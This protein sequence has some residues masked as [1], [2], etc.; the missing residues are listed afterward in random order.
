MR[1]AP[2]L[3]GLAAVWLCLCTALAG[4]GRE[5]GPDKPFLEATVKVN[6][7]ELKDFSLECWVEPGEGTGERR[8]L[9]FLVNGQTK[10]KLELDAQDKLVAEGPQG[11]YGGGKVERGRWTHVAMVS[12]G[13][14]R[15][16]RV[17][18]DGKTVARKESANGNGWNANEFVFRIGGATK[19]DKRFPGRIGRVAWHGRALAEDEIA[20]IAADR[21]AVPANPPVLSWTLGPGDGL[22]STGTA[23]AATLVE[24]TTASAA[25]PAPA[26]PGKGLRVALAGDGWV[27]RGEAGQALQSLLG[28]GHTVQSFG[29]PGLTA[30]KSGATPWL[31]SEPARK[32]AEF[33]PALVVVA[34]GASDTAGDHRARLDAWGADM[35]EI[36]LSLQQLPGLRD[37]LLCTPV[38][39][40]AD[41]AAGA[42]AA[43]ASDKL[44]VPLRLVSVETGTRVVDAAHAA[45]N[46]PNA[47]NT[48]LT[49][50]QAAAVAIA[51][52]ILGRD[53]DI[54]PLAA[55]AP[56]APAPVAAPENAAAPETTAPPAAGSRTRVL[57]IGCPIL[58]KAG[59][60]AALKQAL[61]S[62]QHDVR[63][64]LH[65]DT[66]IAAATG[67]S[68]LRDWRFKDAV[69]HKADVVII[70]LGTRD[71]MDAHFS[72]VGD[73]PRDLDEMVTQ[74]E[75]AE[76]KPRIV[77]CTPLPVPPENRLGITRER[78]A[79]SVAPAIRSVAAAHG[80]PLLD[81]SARLA[82][83]PFTWLTDSVAPQGGAEE[84]AALIA[85]AVAGRVAAPTAK[86]KI[87]VALLGDALTS[88]GLLDRE[89]TRALGIGFEVKPFLALE[90][91]LLHA[92]DKP[93]SRL[94]HLADMRAFRP[95]VVVLCT[96]ED[97]TNA[98][99]PQ[100]VNA[101]ERELRA[102][103][104]QLAA[105]NPRP[106][107][108]LAKPAPFD[109]VTT[110]P[111]KAEDK[112]KKDD[113][114]RGGAPA[115]P[116]TAPAEAVDKA[117][118]AFRLP[119]ADP[120]AALLD[121]TKIP[122][123]DKGVKL[124]ARAFAG[125]IAESVRAM[126][127]ATAAP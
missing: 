84:I 12:S 52:E 111:V 49:A 34:L 60:T 61:P 110:P 67:K 32:L 106:R 77:L 92:G 65:N 62:K 23:A 112:D 9:T 51:R 93:F 115:K 85:D 42:D 78:L 89:V 31:G 44:E 101:L 14:T 57:V 18:V 10:G 95:Q 26:P 64:L 124:F 37:I 86:P 30:L 24:A 116:G 43:V 97:R 7:S 127:P 96:A 2:L 99:T 55:A 104:N 53:P 75:A 69:K 123:G 76:P 6:A 90:S 81:F 1:P 108:I 66:T 109:G 25:P 113:K 45:K 83:R 94:P 98:T 114:R 41:T 120:A 100:E 91:K 118:S 17:L 119:K 126:V 40:E 4:E 80:Q 29:A 103:M 50:T 63:L 121:E 54:K 39:E 20:R 87:R 19:G 74:L 117:A 48:P 58:E 59:V 70:H 71:V 46:P 125:P 56:P 21:T 11:K 105:L 38:V 72:H 33:K 22:T 82:D 88:D 13:S 102:L 122:K 68:F 27:A 35:K 5:F 3:R 16:V 73:V 47:G 36:T 28:N 8:I 15:E 79:E 107:L